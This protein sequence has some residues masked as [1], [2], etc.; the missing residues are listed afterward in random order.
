MIKCCQILHKIIKKRRQTRTLTLIRLSDPGHNPVE[1][2]HGQKN[3]VQQVRAHRALLQKNPKKKFQVFD[4]FLKK[5]PQLLTPS[6]K[7]SRLLLSHKPIPVIVSLLK[8]PEF[9]S[10]PSLRKQIN[11]RIDVVFKRR[12]DKRAYEESGERDR[13]FFLWL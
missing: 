5:N 6:R 11:R 13:E 7:I 10:R 1:V 4:W 2:R 8:M 3:P 12:R 9:L